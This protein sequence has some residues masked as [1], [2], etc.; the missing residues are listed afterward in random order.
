MKPLG[1]RRRWI[2][3]TGYVG[4]ALL[5]LLHLAFWWRA[6]ALHGYW[7][8]FDEASRWFQTIDLLSVVVL[9]CCLLGD[10]W[11]PW[12][13]SAFGLLSLVLSFGYA[14]GL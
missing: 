5:L 11:K 13:G 3:R 12:V 10:G 14:M 2:S 4:V 7:G 9:L 6:G 1:P 8:H